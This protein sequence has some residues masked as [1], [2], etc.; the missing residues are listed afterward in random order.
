MVKGVQREL[1]HKAEAFHLD[2]I[3]QH[4]HKDANGHAHGDVGVC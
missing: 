4:E 1:F 2:R 3:K